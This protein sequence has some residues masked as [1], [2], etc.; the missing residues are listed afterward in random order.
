MLRCC[1]VLS[2]KAGHKA[3]PKGQKKKKKKKGQGESESDMHSDD[4]GSNDDG[5]SGKGSVKK[6]KKGSHR[7]SE[8]RGRDDDDDDLDSKVVVAS[9]LST[10]IGP[11]PLS[12]CF[13]H[14]QGMPAAT[15]SGGLFSRRS[16][17]GLC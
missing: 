10:S 11:T 3:A 6:E 13:S 12:L 17:V 7:A 15:A 5:E 4:A 9:K 8:S 1:K 16:A 14:C 2:K